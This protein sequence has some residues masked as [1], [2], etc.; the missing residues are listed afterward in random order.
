MLSLRGK[1]SGPNSFR[2]EV[3][4]N[5]KRIEPQRQV[6]MRARELRTRLIQQSNGFS[7]GH[8]TDRWRGGGREWW[9][10]RRGRGGR[11]QWRGREECLT[12]APQSSISAAQLSDS[13]TLTKYLPYWVSYITCA[14]CTVKPLQ[15]FIIKLNFFLKLDFGC[16]SRWFAAQETFL[17]IIDFENSRAA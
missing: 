6:F 12:A 2:L 13:H 14:G 3:W 5:R 15:N 11:E 16:C 8:N 9:D 4:F 1:Y 10:R 17:I 7:D